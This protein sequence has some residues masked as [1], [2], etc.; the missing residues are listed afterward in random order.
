VPPNRGERFH[1]RAGSRGGVGGRRRGSIYSRRRRRGGLEEEGRRGEW[2][3]G[4]S[5]LQ[6][7]EG[8]STGLD[9]RRRKR[10]GGGGCPSASGS[11]HIHARAGHR[12]GNNGALLPLPSSFF[13]SEAV[14]S[15]VLYIHPLY[16]S[17]TVSSKRFH[18]LYLLPLQQRPLNYVLYTQISILETFFIFIFCTYVFVM[19]SNVLYIF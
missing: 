9:G 14:F 4:G 19:L 10:G 18:P 17:F 1:L 3:V 12:Q 11:R 5:Q 7:R 15:N 16:P 6:W 8:D 2:S 13:P